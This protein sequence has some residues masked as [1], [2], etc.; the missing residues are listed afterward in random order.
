MAFCLS[1]LHIAQ[2]HN[3]VF[4][5]IKKKQCMNLFKKILITI[6]AIGSLTSLQA[7]YI[8]VDT[9]RRS[10]I[11]SIKRDINLNAPHAKKTITYNSFLVSGTIIAYGFIAIENNSLQYLPMIAFVT[12]YYQGNAGGLSCV[13]NFK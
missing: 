3:P 9:I 1:L 8:I 4:S 7:Q 12:H 2:L 6:V 13:C 11:D 10:G 5:T